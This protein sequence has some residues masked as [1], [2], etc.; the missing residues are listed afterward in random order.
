MRTR[1][2][3]ARS[4]P[5]PMR[6]MDCC[7]RYRIGKILGNFSRRSPDK[8]WDLDVDSES[9]AIEVCSTLRDHCIP[10]LDGVRTLQAAKDQ[11]ERKLETMYLDPAEQ[12]LLAAIS[13]RL[14]DRQTATRI[15]DDLASSEYWRERVGAVR[16]KLGIGGD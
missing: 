14:G 3:W 8:W 2:S 5:D 11:A 7:P 13:Y 1:Q 12:L 10:F 9:L 15:L 16:H 4:V 6:E